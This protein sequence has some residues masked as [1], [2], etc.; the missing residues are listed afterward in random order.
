[1]KRILVIVLTVAYIQHLHAPLVTANTSGVY[2]LG[3]S[4][5]YTPT[6]PGDSIILITANDVTIDLNGSVLSQENSF[7]SVNGITINSGLSG[8]TIKNGTLA[9]LT[10]TG[11]QIQAG[12]S[13]ILIDN[14]VTESADQCGIALNG[15]AGNSVAFLHISNCSITHCAQGDS[16][17]SGITAQQ[18][19][20]VDILDTTI[21]SCGTAAHSFY[22]IY[23]NSCTTCN[24][25][26]VII[27]ENKAGH[28][29]ASSKLLGILLEHVQKSTLRGCSV[30]N[31]TALTATVE[32]A[33]IELLNSSSNVISE[34]IVLGNAAT[35]ASSTVIG[36]EVETLGDAGNTVENC[37]VASNAA[38]ALFYG[39]YLENSQKS[40]LTNFLCQGNMVLTGTCNG[41]FLNRCSSCSIYQG[42]VD[43]NSGTTTAG[44][45]MQSC[46]GCSINFLISQNNV[47]TILGQGIVIS[48]S[49]NSIL[50]K[51]IAARNLGPTNATSYGIRIINTLGRSAFLTN[52]AVRNCLN[53]SGGSGNQLNGFP[54]SMFANDNTGNTN[55]ADPI[56]SNF[57]ETG[58]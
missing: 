18:C 39:F 44:V 51:N 29:T 17:N 37:T 26:D 16:G 12:C 36:I 1:M 53:A 25:H 3:N 10:G 41:I 20:N 9:N 13:M 19:A 21:H 27:A 45:L 52:M 11:I 7:S 50:E 35:L 49:F 32:L 40:V 46:T 43:N 28:T 48:N 23:L 15:T 54:A 31:N 14:I 30:I 8:I 57:G 2:T 34:C 6:T 58:A 33:G 42:I 56:W 55:V 22:G 5:A 47:G 24:I 4:I 38:R